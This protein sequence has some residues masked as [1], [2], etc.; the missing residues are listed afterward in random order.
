M[1]ITVEAVTNANPKT[2]WKCF[3]TP[4]DVLV[5]NTASDDWHCT[6]SKVDLRIGGK[7]F[8]RMEAKDGSFGFDFGGTHMTVEPHS[9]IEFQLEDGREV[10]VEFTESSEGTLVRE[11]FDAEAENDAEMQRAGWQAI[12]DNFARYASSQ[13]GV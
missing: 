7:L 3:C 11:T 1:K 9:I 6:K 8:S 13:S 10:T 12:L 2:E 4:E 5:W